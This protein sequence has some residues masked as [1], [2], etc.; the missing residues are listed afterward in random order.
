[1]L[2]KDFSRGVSVGCLGEQVSAAG[3]GVPQELDG[4]LS[5]VGSDVEND[6]CCKE[7]R[8][9]YGGITFSSEGLTGLSLGRS[10]E[11]ISVS[12]C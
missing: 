11:D 6:E 3:G 7:V 8:G 2:R 1:M 9:I 5:S 4:E 10:V 12:D